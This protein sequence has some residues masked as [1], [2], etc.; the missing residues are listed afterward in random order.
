[1]SEMADATK[2][3]EQ[4]GAGEGWRPRDVLAA[5]AVFIIILALA[6]GGYLFYQARQN[7]PVIE[8]DQAPDFTLPLLDGGQASL[9]D[10]RGKVVLLNVW[11]TWCAPCRTEMPYME[12]MYQSLQGQPFEIL[13]VSID[14]RGAEDVGPFVRELGLTFPILLDP[15]KQIESLYRTSRVP[16]SFIIDK[17]GVVRRLV[18]GP[19]QPAHFEEVR[20]LLMES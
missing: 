10:Q 14:D 1:M 3:E 19:L 13:A 2:I 9:A 16:E 17:N 5:L 6:V 11:A 7:P 15:D 8:G 20:Q 12:R 18:I 4:D